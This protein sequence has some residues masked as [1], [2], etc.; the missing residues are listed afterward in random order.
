M[1]IQRQLSNSDW[2]DDNEIL[3]RVLPGIIKIDPW[4][5]RR[6]K[7]E[8]ITTKE[9]ALDLLE[10]G[11]EVHYDTDWYAK[12]RKAPVPVR[13]NPDYL[14]GRVLDCGCTVYFKSDVMNANNG[15]SCPN[16]YDRM[17]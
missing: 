8:P 14:N 15:T 13:S 6:E 12:I 5:A 2:T 16:C 1:N 9:Q 4:Y 11:N 3:D 17:S 10:A 7:R